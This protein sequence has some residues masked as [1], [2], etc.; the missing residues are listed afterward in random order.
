MAHF[1][2]LSAPY[3]A[4]WI[5]HFIATFFFPHWL[6]SSFS[7]CLGLI[8][9]PILCFA[10][11][12]WNATTNFKRLLLILMKFL[13]FFFIF[14]SYFFVS[15]EKLS[16]SFNYWIFKNKSNVFSISFMLNKMKEFEHMKHKKLFI[17]PNLAKILQKNWKKNF[18][19]YKRQ[20]KVLSCSL[21]KKILQTIFC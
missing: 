14:F 3:D 9:T 6:V 13:K 2:C 12:L 21:R 16:K 5:F 7:G 19:Y 15:W 1:L 11:I 10:N 17:L 18:L 20:N 4:R 8:E